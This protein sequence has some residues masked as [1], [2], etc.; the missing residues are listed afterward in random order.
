MDDATHYDGRRL[1]CQTQ[2]RSDPAGMTNDVHARSRPIPKGERTRVRIIDAARLICEPGAAGTTLDDV[3]CDEAMAVLHIYIGLAAAAHA[4]AERYPGVA[5]H[6]AACGACA[7]DFAG[8][9]LAA[10]TD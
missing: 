3:G 2:K 7:E 6:F 10:A 5:A 1:G 8:L 4:P 9:L